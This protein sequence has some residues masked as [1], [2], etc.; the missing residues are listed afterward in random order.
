MDDDLLRCV[1]PIVRYFLSSPTSLVQVRGLGKSQFDPRRGFT[2]AGMAAQTSEL[3]YY[4]FITVLNQEG[5]VQF[6][7]YTSLIRSDSTE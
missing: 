6:H 4:G 2:F 1:H 5:T 7:I 3:A